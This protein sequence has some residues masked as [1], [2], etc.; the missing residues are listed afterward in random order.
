MQNMT[1]T[2]ICLSSLLCL[3]F[4]QNLMAAELSKNHQL[5]PKL[6]AQLSDKVLTDIEIMQGADQTHSLYGYCIQETTAKLKAM[7]PEADQQT[8][9]STID[10][11]CIYPED[12]FN[13]YSILIAASG[14]KKPM[15]EKQAAVF[16]ENDYEK[17]GR[18]QVNHKQ[19][20]HIYKT[21]G[22]LKK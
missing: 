10:Q 11:S 14:M 15:S 2:K 6:K 16:L 4:T 18:D 22:I 13:I 1:K 5:A 9:V 21:L 12:R 19:R 17:T 7:Y 8:V 3:C 20:T